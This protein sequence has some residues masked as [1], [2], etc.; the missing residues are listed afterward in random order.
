[1]GPPGSPANGQAIK[2]RLRGRGGEGRAIKEKTF[3][4]IKKSSDDDKAFFT[5][6]ICTFEY[7]P[8][9]GADGRT[10]GNACAVKFVYKL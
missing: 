6:C 7:D 10:Y 8:V 4:R 9:C 3:F 1:M 5:G 2:S